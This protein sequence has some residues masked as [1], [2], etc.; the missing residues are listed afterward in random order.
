[1]PDLAHTIM[2]RLQSWRSQTEPTTP[3][4]TRPG[5][6][7]LTLGQDSI[8]WR[9][10]LEGTIRTA[11]AGKQQEYL[12]WLK[13]R[14]TRKRWVTTL[15]NEL[16][17]ISWDLWEQRSGELTNP[18]YPALLQEHAWL[19]ALIILEC[20]DQTTLA[21]RDR[22]LL[23]HPEQ[24]LFTETSEY[25]ERWLESVRLAQAK[26][27]CRHKA[28]THAQCSLIRSTFHRTRQQ[29]PSSTN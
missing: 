29:Q 21:I 24:V 16:R 10:F 5:V 25:K 4:C 14:N 1:M 3:T 12:V 7:D 22:R 19:D 27:A 26:Y 11:W 17:D 20:Q 23:R 15:I 28:S 6:N 18:A 8:G 2:N 9:A 13:R